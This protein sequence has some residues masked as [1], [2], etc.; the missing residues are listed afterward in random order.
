MSTHNICFRREVRKILCGYPLLSVAM[1]TPLHLQQNIYCGSSLK[2]PCQDKSK[3][4][5]NLLCLLQK[6]KKKSL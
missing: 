3:E 6:Y 1:T 4:Y 5:Y 2:W